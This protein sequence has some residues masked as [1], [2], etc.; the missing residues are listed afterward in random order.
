MEKIYVI[1]ACNNKS[2]EDYLESDLGFV[3]TEQEA[4]RII[5]VLKRTQINDYEIVNKS[6]SICEYCNGHVEECFNYCSV[7]NEIDRI[8]RK[9]MYLSCCGRVGD[10]IYTYKELNKMF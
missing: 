4:K 2:Y 6:E 7:K 3:E 8:E 10:V 9:D 5:D 1:V